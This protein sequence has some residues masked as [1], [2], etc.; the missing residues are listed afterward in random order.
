MSSNPDLPE[1]LCGTTA[2]VAE[3]AGPVPWHD[4]STAPDLP[5]QTLHSPPRKPTLVAQF[6]GTTFAVERRRL[7]GTPD[8]PERSPEIPEGRAGGTAGNLRITRA[9]PRHHAS[10]RRQV[11]RG[12]CKCL[13]INQ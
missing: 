10:G 6:P 4:R 3:P 7:N 8:L 12:E 1:H 13:M 5:N 9:Q 2:A 11:F